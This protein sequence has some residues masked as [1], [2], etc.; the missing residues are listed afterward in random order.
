MEDSVL[1][2]PVCHSPGARDKSSPR[3]GRE[4]SFSSGALAAME[5]ADYWDD[6]GVKTGMEIAFGLPDPD[7][8]SSWKV[9]EEEKPEEWSSV[10]LHFTQNTTFHGINKITENTPFP[11]RR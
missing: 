1:S 10:C 4:T 5:R 8:A 7:P 11:V 3:G 2:I 6:Y 9:L